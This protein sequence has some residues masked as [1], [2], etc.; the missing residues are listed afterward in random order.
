MWS[1]AVRKYVLK[2][3]EESDGPDKAN[4]DILCPLAISQVTRV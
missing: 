2:L 4:Q 3:Y 1:R